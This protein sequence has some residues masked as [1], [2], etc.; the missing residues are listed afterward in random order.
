MASPSDARDKVIKQ[1]VT[2]LWLN[3]VEI[4]R[5]MGDGRKQNEDTFNYRS[6]LK[7]KKRTTLNE[8][9]MSHC[10]RKRYEITIGNK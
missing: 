10:D 4:E 9:V 3:K 8:D 2:Q 1:Y 7:Q 5:E 6:A